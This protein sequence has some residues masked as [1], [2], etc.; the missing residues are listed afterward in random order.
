MEITQVRPTDRVAWALAHMREH[1]NRTVSASSPKDMIGRVS[2]AGAGGGYEFRSRAV[3]GPLRQ[4]AKP[5]AE[6]G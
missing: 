2:D 1:P 5:F 3:E 4:R 6:A